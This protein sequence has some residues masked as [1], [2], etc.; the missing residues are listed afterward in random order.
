VAS[1]VTGGGRSKCAAHQYACQV[2]GNLGQP[3]LLENI[4]YDDSGIVAALPSPHC[5]WFPVK[6]VRPIFRG[7][8]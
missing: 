8:S 3:A 2:S 1:R 4:F 6:C 5:G 7:S